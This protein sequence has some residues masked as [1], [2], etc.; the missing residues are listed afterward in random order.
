MTPESLQAIKEHT[1]WLKRY[2]K[3]LEDQKKE[4]TALSV[5]EL[6]KIT[7]WQTSEELRRA[8]EKGYVKVKREQ[9]KI[10]YIKDSIDPMFLKNRTA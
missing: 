5:F 1:Q 3:M 4:Q 8:R 6:K 7:V 2:C 10:R 9:G